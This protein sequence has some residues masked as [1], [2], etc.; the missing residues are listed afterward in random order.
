[1]SSMQLLRIKSGIVRRISREYESYH[2]EILLDKDRISKLK[3]NGVDGY[4]IRKQEEVLSET[5]SMIPNTYKRLQDALANISEFM[6]ECD[7]NEDVI[8][9]E[10]WKLAQQI[11][12]KAREIVQ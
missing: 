8:E 5:I 6:K 7:S 10:D 2:R 11:T 4:T 3:S 9:S 12:G 1:M